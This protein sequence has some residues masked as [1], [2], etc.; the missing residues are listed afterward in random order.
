M[1]NKS[2]LIRIIEIPQVFD[3]CFLYFAQHPTHI[4]FKIKRVYYIVGANTRLIRGLHAHKKTQ[5]II[6]CI[7]GTIKLLLDNGKKKEEILLDKPNVGVFLEEMVW[8]EMYEFKKNTILLVL[9]SKEFS[10]KDYIRD[11][12]DFKK[13]TSEIS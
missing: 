10:E 8:H 1:Q 6:F 4:P 7:Q 2:K 9:A 5:Q 12:E 3:D 13:R 11:Y